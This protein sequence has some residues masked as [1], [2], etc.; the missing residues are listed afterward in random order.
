MNIKL[1]CKEVCVILYIICVYIIYIY[2]N[3]M[4]YYG[5]IYNIIFET[6]FIIIIIKQCT[7]FSYGPYIATKW[8]H[9]SGNYIHQTIDESKQSGLITDRWAK[10]GAN[11]LSLKGLV[12]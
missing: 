12:I 10:R 4:L 5:I 6:C 3:N 7:T 8:I 2:N 1:Q 11:Q 9:R